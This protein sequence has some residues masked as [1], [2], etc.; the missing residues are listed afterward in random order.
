MVGFLEDTIL[1][2]G[3]L[4]LILLNDNFLF[5]NLDCEKLSRGLLAAQNDLSECAFAQNF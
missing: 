2:H 4:H 3:V 1:S 5:Q